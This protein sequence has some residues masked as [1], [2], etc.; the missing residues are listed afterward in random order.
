MPRR[1]RLLAALLAVVA[2]LALVLVAA[3]PAGAAT[4]GPHLAFTQTWTPSSP[5]ADDVIRFTY[6]VT[7]DGDAPSVGTVLDITVNLGSYQWAAVSGACP[8]TNGRLDAGIPEQVM[9][10]HLGTLAPGQTVT[11]VVDYRAA[12]GTTSRFVS[13]HNADYTTGGFDNPIVT[14]APGHNLFSRLQL[15]LYLL[16][17]R[18]GL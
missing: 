12:A 18:L 6:T 4:P 11:K 13:F 15:Y 9:T 7:N 1:P 2:T 17:G 14:V 16:L 10:C 8:I 5:T 3:G